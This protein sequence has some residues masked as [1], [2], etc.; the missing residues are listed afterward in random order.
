M[1]SIFSLLEKSAE[2]FPDKSAIIFDNISFSYSDLLKKSQILSNYIQKRTSE[3][4][5]VSILCENS[6]FFVISYFGILKSGCIAHII[7]PTIS[8]SNLT[9][10]IHETNPKIILS[11][12]KYKQKLSRTGYIE[13]T[14]FDENANEFL[15]I[16]GSEFFGNRFHNVSTIIFTS[17]TT[18]K[19]K[20]VKLT[21]TNVLTA[22]RNIVEK[23]NLCSSDVEINSLSLS[24]S[25]GL[26]CLHAIFYQGSTVLL[27]K[28]T[29]NLE[30]I[31]TN[32]KTTMLLDLLVYLQPFIKF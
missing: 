15:K 21:H 22:T 29:I 32:A 14:L 1:N 28:N 3:G 2:N 8:D 5:V 9:K 11:N 4:D 23:L 12:T 6:P 18:S 25:F 7:P 20:G 13:K 17:G 24:H 30:S 16:G 26:G 27:F 10:Q 31:L 19:P